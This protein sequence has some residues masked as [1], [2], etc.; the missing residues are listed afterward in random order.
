MASTETDTSSDQLKPSRE[1]RGVPSGLWLKCIDCNAMVFRKQCEEQMN[2][3]PECD[4]HMYISANDRIRTVLDSG[5]F[6]EWDGHL[7]P[8][9]PLNFKD[10]KTYKDRLVAEQKRTGLKEPGAWR[11]V[12]PTRRSS[13]AAWDRSL[14]N[15]SPGSSNGRPRSIFR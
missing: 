8:T 10:K 6:E 15:G 5:T 11:L 4:Y 14:A 12:L 9:D 7:A 2:V 13:W 1:K 3:C